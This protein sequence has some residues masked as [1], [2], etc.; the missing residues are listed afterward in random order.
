MARGAPVAGLA[1]L[2]LLISDSRLGPCGRCG[3]C[4]RQSSLRSSP[5]AAGGTTGASSGSR[6]RTDGYCAEYYWD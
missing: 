3:H 2:P 6:R 4:R 5:F 1:R